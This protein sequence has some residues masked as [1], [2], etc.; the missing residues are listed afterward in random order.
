MPADI[1]ALDE[2]VE[3]AQDPDAVRRQDLQ[4]GD[5]LRIR[6]RNS[7]YTICALEEGTYSVSGG[8]FDREGASPQ[9]T[10]IRG[11]TLGGSALLTEVLAA[12]G[13]F[14]EFGND[15]RTT[16]IQDVRLIRQEAAAAL[17]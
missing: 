13:L 8:W 11:C 5:W 3:Q 4:Q 16:R 2:I 12:P 15:V 6:T 10:T 7:T 1:L 14:L 17:T 9:R